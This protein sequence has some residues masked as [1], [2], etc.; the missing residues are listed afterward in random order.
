MLLFHIHNSGRCLSFMQGELPKKVCQFRLTDTKLVNCGKKI[1]LHLDERL[2]RMQLC[3]LARS[4]HS[5][6]MVAK[7][8]RFPSVVSSLVR[9][10]L[11]AV[12]AKRTPGLTFFS[13]NQY[14]ST[15]TSDEFNA[16]GTH[17]AER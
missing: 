14:A 15:K 6:G 9:H 3:N 17:K 7:V 10:C 12:H 5:R 1:A 2:P 16:V 11:A 4:E 13:P 8:A